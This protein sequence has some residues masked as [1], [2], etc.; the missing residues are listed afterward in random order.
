[1]AD[2]YWRMERHQDVLGGWHEQWVPSPEMEFLMG[3]LL[4]TQEE[5][6]KHTLLRPDRILLPAD[7]LPP[8]AQDGGSLLGIP[9]EASGKVT[10]PSLVYPVRFHPAVDLSNLAAGTTDRGTT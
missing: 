5:I 4:S 8:E 2:P 9:F 6:E 3:C 7:R 10:T 1:M